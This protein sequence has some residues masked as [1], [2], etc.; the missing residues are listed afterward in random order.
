MADSMRKMFT[1]LFLTISIFAL[2]TVGQ[3]DCPTTVTGLLHQL[4]IGHLTD[5]EQSMGSHSLAY[6]MLPSKT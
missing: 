4:N 6:S 1:T 3:S 2:L 5:A